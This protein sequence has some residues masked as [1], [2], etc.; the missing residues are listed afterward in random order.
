MYGQIKEWG[1]Y[2]YHAKRNNTNLEIIR[3]ITC[4]WDMISVL[5]IVSLSYIFNMSQTNEKVSRLLGQ[6][7]TA[8]NCYNS[9]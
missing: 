4:Y 2:S 6:H 9:I 3:E 1:C 7:I 5:V 8:N